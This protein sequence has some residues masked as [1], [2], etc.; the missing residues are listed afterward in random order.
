MRP[1]RSLPHKWRTLIHLGSRLDRCLL[2]HGI[3]S[4]IPTVQT[5]E[6]SGIPAYDNVLLAFSLHHASSKGTLFTCNT[7]RECVNFQHGRHHGT[8]VSDTLQRCPP[9]GSA[10]LQRGL[11][12]VIMITSSSAPPPLATTSL[13]CP[14]CNK[15]YTKRKELLHHLRTSTDEQHKTLRYCACELAHILTRSLLGV[16]PYP[17]GCGALFDGGSSGTSRPLDAHIARCSCRPRRLGSSPLPRELNGPYMP[18]TTRGVSAAID[19]HAA[20]ARL[21]P[22][23]T[24]V[25]A[26]ANTFCSAN[27]EFTATHMRT[28]GTQSAAALHV[29]AL[30]QQTPGITNLIKRA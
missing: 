26:A 22:S 25:N 6:P 27:P 23:T 15:I 10:S 12:R 7:R 17:L 16:L 19:S 14:T 1:T 3:H 28:S 8:R 2:L 29:P 5:L 24:P 18:T 21:D 11:S 9:E 13:A 4:R 20:Q 30:S